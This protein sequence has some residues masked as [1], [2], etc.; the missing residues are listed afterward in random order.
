M[1]EFE[2]RFPSPQN[3]IEI[4]PGEWTC[5]IPNPNDRTRSLPSGLHGLFWDD[6]VEW[7]IARCGGVAGKRILE[8]GPLEGG[9]SYMFEQAGAAEVIAIEANRRAFLR[10]LVVQNMLR[11][12]SVRFEVGDFTEYL[13]QTTETFDVISA[14]GV[15]YHQLDP[16]RMLSDMARI[17]SQV[18]VWTHYYDEAAIARNRSLDGKVG[19]LIEVTVDG[20][21]YHWA[22][23]RYLRA[24]DWV[25]FSGGSHP[26]AHWLPRDEILDE[27]RRG[28]FRSFDI[29]YDEPDHANGP[30]FAF[31]ASK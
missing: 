6:R 7:A 29:A 17:A 11:L 1:S 23:F 3:A 15:L 30:A 20:R 18:I 19:P 13:R 4:F 22:E 10:C 16:I 31:V 9:H 27:L 21:T 28:G 24:L 12:K 14:S 2:R 5:A 8:L 26:E 25:G